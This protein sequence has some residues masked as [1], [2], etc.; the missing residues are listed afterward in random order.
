MI[1]NREYGAM[2]RNDTAIAMLRQ[3][4]LIV[5]KLAPAPPPPAVAPVAPIP[6]P[7]FPVP[8]IDPGHGGEPRR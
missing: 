8:I 3:I 6:V 2:R 1:H 5:V 4:N 7:I